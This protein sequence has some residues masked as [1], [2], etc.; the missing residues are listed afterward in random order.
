MQEGNE[1]LIQNAIKRFE[2]EENEF[3]SYLKRPK[4]AN[5]NV[6]IEKPNDI[7]KKSAILIQ[8]PIDKDDD[9][10]LETIKM[11]EV[12]YPGV[13]IVLSTW[14]N[15]DKSIID[16][17]KHETKAKIVL[18]DYPDFT[19]IGNILYQIT[20]TM[21]GLEKIKELEKEWIFKTRTD[22]RFYKKGIMSAMYGLVNQ[23]ALPDD[24]YYQKYR[25]IGGQCLLGGMFHPFYIAD[26]Y[27]YGHIEDMYNYWNY[28][29]QANKAR[30]YTKAEVIQLKKDNNYNI[31]QMV[32]N[33]LIVEATISRNYLERME[34]N[35][36]EATIY[37]YWN[38]VKNNFVIMG[39]EDLGAFWHKY[40][41]RYV[42]SVRNG[43]Y[44]SNDSTTF[45]RAYNWDFV[46]W[47]NLY[48]GLLEYDEEYEKIP[49]NQVYELYYKK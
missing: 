28:S 19:G 25:M 33:N 40:D 18:S 20:S 47:L 21:A 37:N 32:D 29:F 27:M 15:E 48:N 6:S 5:Q 22:F 3:A 30:N 16:R 7:H 2:S 36:P 14:K 43:T 38:F 34:G 46:N 4:Y 39:R 10:T 13:L 11:Y 23:F 8:G 31:N 12:I 24:I 49:V 26:Q 9:F 35:L 41:I 44:Y 1:Q 42:E 45:L 17:I